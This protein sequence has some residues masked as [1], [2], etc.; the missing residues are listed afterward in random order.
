MKNPDS[1]SLPQG[2]KISI[3]ANVPGARSLAKGPDGSIF[4]G[5]RDSSGKVYLVNY[6]SGADNA[7]DV[8]VIAENLSSPNGVAFKDGNLYVGEIEKILIFE[9]VLG[10]IKK[11]VAPVTFPSEEHH[12]YK[13]LKFSPQGDLIVPVG[14][15]CNICI[16]D[17]HHGKIF[18]VNL[19][20]GSKKMIAQGVRNTVGFDFH[21]KT[22]ELW[23][24]D[25]GRD[26]L[27]EDIPPDELNRLGIE[28]AHFGFP[29]CHGKNLTDPRFKVK[30]GCSG[31]TPPA[32]ELGAHV[33]PLGMAFYT[34][35]SFPK[36]YQ[37]QIFIAEHGSWNRKNPQGYR[38]MLVKLEGNQAVSYSTFAEGWLDKDGKRSGRPVDLLVIEDG[39]I[40]ISD[41][42][43]G[44][45]YRISY[46]NP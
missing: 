42:F 28:G 7:K 33:A 4:V 17:D 31:F 6:Q 13:Y 46:S 36:E 25:N 38:I 45:L 41:D 34:G 12:G 24:T 26:W 43:A 18:S 27:G 35:K 3:F 1:I 22:L 11:K 32:I 8:K 19:K 5:T 37:N 29:H 23:F 16:P 2:F 44:L 20:T 21:P 10:D 30:K 40:I 15:P 14:A 9:N 39:S